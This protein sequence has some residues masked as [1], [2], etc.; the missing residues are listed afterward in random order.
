MWTQVLLPRN[1]KSFV[2]DHLVCLSKQLSGSVQPIVLD[3][4]SSHIEGN[5]QSNSKQ[6]NHA[7]IIK[8]SK[9]GRQEDQTC[10]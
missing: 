7:V 6:S 4:H 1:V 5:V 10:K 3:V 8:Q 9:T 2:P